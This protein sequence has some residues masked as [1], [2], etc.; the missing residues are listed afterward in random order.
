MKHIKIFIG[1]L[2]CV[3][4]G[5]WVS[6]A[7]APCANFWQSTI[8]TP[9]QTLHVALQI[10]PQ[11]QAE[12][13][14]GCKN[15]P[16]NTGM[17]FLFSGLQEEVFWMKGMLI[18]IDIVWIADSKVVGIEHHVPN[19]PLGTPDEALKQYASPEGVDMVLEIG[20]DTASKYGI[21][22]GSTLILDRK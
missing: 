3:G 14:S 2:V 18:P 16:T 12:G 9:T 20:A 13:L 19:E 4:A 21:E 17:A 5:V 7:V 8:T 6:H 11:E 10:T 22:V 1:V 15:V